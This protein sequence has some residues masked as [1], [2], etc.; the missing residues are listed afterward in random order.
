M[1]FSEVE[2]V[3]S[4]SELNYLIRSYLFACNGKINIGNFLTFHKDN[5]MIV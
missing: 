1:T 2:A 4:S 5:I 3:L